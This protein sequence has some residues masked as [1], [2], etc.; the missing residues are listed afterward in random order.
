MK[1]C[2]NFV[3]HFDVDGFIETNHICTQDSHS[4]FSP[5]IAPFQWYFRLKYTFELMVAVKRAIFVSGR[6]HARSRPIHSQNLS[7]QFLFT[8]LAKSPAPP[9]SLPLQPR[10]V[11]SPLGTLFLPPPAGLLIIR[12][13]VADRK[14]SGPW[15]SRM[16]WPPSCCKRRDLTCRCVCLIKQERFCDWKFN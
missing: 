11:S 4:R 5:W 8:E 2:K 9:R 13:T 1:G 7:H 14:A 16:A 6:I 3:F 12:E 10:A 15:Y